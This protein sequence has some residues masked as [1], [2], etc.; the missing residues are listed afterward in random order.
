VRRLERRTLKQ[1]LESAKPVSNPFASKSNQNVDLED[2]D[3]VQ[4]KINLIS[5]QSSAYKTQVDNN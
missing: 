2:L 4:N 3:D 1:Q 5:Q